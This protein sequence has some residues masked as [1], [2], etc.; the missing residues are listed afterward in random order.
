MDRL[1]WIFPQVLYM[2]DESGDFPVP[3]TP[4]KEFAGP[5]PGDTVTDVVANQ[6]NDLFDNDD[7][8][9]RIQDGDLISAKVVN[10]DTVQP[11]RQ[12]ARRYGDHAGRHRRR[13]WRR[14]GR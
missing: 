5:E 12:R 8:V 13:P 14:H 9:D 7:L 10:E 3:P 2:A 4:P 11:G 1:T 6:K